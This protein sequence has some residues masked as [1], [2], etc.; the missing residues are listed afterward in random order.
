MNTASTGTGPVPVV[1]ND[2]STIPDANLPGGLLLQPADVSLS[3]NAAIG[4]FSGDMDNRDATMLA[5]FCLVALWIT[6]ELMDPMGLSTL[7]I[8]ILEI[9]TLV[10]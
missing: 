10:S 1:L 9:S 3:A 5:L 8:S 6:K 2:G 4:Q 7:R